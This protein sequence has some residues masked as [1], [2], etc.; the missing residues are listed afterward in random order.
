M[1]EQASDDEEETFQKG[2][3]QEDEILDN[4][5][6]A[7]QPQKKGNTIRDHAMDRQRKLLNIIMKIAMIKGY[8]DQGHIKDRNGNFLDG[9]DIVPLI[10]YSVTKERLVKGLDAYVDLLVEAKVPPEV[11]TNENLKQRLLN[12]AHVNHRPKAISV[13]TTSA[14]D[15]EEEMV[16]TETPVRKVVKAKRVYKKK[17]VNPQ[18][19]NLPTTRSRKRKQDEENVDDIA[20]KLLKTNDKTN[21]GYENVTDSEDE[22]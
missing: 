3:G 8:N 22:S 4:V 21:K 16:H 17:T 15:A 11:I 20:H 5:G 7:A 14:A 12:A 10:L 1:P 2:R 13:P 9:T 18:V 19:E 6:Q